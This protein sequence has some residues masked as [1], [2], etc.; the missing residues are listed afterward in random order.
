MA[1]SSRDRPLARRVDAG[2][3]TWLLRR[4][5][6]RRGLPRLPP[7]TL[8]FLVMAPSRGLLSGCGAALLQHVRNLR[9]RPALDAADL[10]RLGQHPREPPSP[11]GCPVD[12]KQ[13]REP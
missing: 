12:I 2:L 3:R 5:E 13:F 8:V 9:F 1:Y 6:L 10:H 4:L 11:D 7:D